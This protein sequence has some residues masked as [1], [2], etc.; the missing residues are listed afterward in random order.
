MEGLYC[1]ALAKAT[2]KPVK[3]VISK[4]AHLATYMLRL[5]SRLT[6]KVGLLS[7]TVRFTPTREPGWSAQAFTPTLARARSP[8]GLGRAM[9]LLNK[10]KHWNYQPHLV[11]TNRCRSGG[12]RGFGGQESYA[13][14]VPVLSMAMAK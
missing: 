10:C 12:I 5:G 14:L 13:S 6:A 1:A 4:E 3:L 11:A 7:P 2:G 9:L 8:T